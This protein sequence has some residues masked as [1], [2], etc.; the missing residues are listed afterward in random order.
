MT[1]PHT[2]VS[3]SHT[4]KQTCC[5]QWS[6][7]GISIYL[8]PRQIH[9]YWLFNYDSP[10]QPATSS[11]LTSQDPFKDT[12]A[13]LATH[14]QLGFWD[15]LDVSKGLKTGLELPRLKYCHVNSPIAI[16]YS[17]TCCAHIV[18]F[19]CETHEKKI[20]TWI[21]PTQWPSLWPHLSSLLYGCSL[22]IFAYTFC[23]FNVVFSVKYMQYAI[24]FCSYWHQI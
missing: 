18:L 6:V 9:F 15:R 23:T 12:H 1:A 16:I 4:H 20:F 19:V 8:L 11:P 14:R 24:I 22:C 21:F 5:W 7:R 13:A 17:P 10:P 3:H 2:P